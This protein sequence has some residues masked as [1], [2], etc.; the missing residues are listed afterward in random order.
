MCV[1]IKGSNRKEMEYG[2]TQAD[3]PNPHIQPFFLCH[4]FYITMYAL[5]GVRGIICE[6]SHLVHVTLLKTKE[7]QHV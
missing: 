6:G 3:S 1:F 2:D 7:Q 4:N 5:C